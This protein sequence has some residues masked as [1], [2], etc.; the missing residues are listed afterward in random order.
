MSSNLG[1]VSML[2]NLPLSKM[3]FNF[4]QC[5]PDHTLD[6]SLLSESDRNAGWPLERVSSRLCCSMEEWELDSGSTVLPLWQGVVPAALARFDCGKLLP[7]HV[8]EQQ[9]WPWGVPASCPPSFCWN[10]IWGQ[11][12]RWTA[13]NDAKRDM[14]LEFLFAYRWQTKR[15]QFNYFVSEDWHTSRVIFSL[16]AFI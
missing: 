3:P 4:S 9:S 10:K 11:S 12:R 13:K 2:V 14:V 1:Q 5:L 6:P 7:P 8:G 15:F 16:Q